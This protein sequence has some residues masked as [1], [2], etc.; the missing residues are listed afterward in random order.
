MAD[1]NPRLLRRMLLLRQFPMFATAEL[2]E[3][4]TIAE[5]LVETEFAPG[6][7]IA[8][9]GARLPGLHFV[10]DGR[11]H[12]R[13]DPGGRDPASSASWSW[14]RA[15]RA[16]RERG[17]SEGG[18]L[19]GSAH[20][21][22]GP[23]EIF[24]ELEAFAGRDHAAHAVATTE[25]R[26]L[27]LA[28]SDLAEIVE[29][30]FGVLIAVVRDLA[31]RLLATRSRAPAIALPR[32][33]PG[34]GLVERLIALRQLAPFVGTRLQGLAM[35]AH[36]SEEVSWAPG[37]TVVR[38]GELASGF[39][40]VLDGALRAHEPGGATSELAAGQAFGGLETL[41]GVG[42][43]ATLVAASPVRALYSSATAMFDV[44]EDHP[45]IAM[46][47]IGVFARGLLDRPS[48]E[49]SAPRG[50]AN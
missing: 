23:R 14:G 47:M 5:N 27:L 31:A 26:T 8:P 9:A 25:T 35:L 11:I 28:A 40:L 18:G 45:D 22:W 34:L 7:V 13:G 16:V 39:A 6:A 43:G 32:V 24:G 10:L 46:S 17:E 12:E 19:A 33:G 49:P 2:S 15:R 48:P 50:A 20:R 1:V 21:S 38:A 4:A 44:L 36:S 42:H 29:D 3:L 30:N 41:A 37:A